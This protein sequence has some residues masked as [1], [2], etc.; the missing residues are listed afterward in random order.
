MEHDSNAPQAQQ[1]SL[2]DTGET[3]AEISV[4][5]DSTETTVRDIGRAL[6]TLVR[7]HDAKAVQS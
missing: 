6:T 2:F 5:A 4:P 7:Y 1:L 3:L